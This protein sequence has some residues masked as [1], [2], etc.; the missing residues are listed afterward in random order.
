MSRA[1]PRPPRQRRP[2]RARRRVTVSIPI[3]VSVIEA[4]RATGSGWRKRI[5]AALADWLK[6]RNP[7]DAPEQS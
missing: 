3:D 7:E 1:H 5:N 4:F 2:R 6:S